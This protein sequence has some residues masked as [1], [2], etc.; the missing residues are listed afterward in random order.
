MN[1]AIVVDSDVSRWGLTTSV[2]AEQ[3]WT[4]VSGQDTSGAWSMFES[5]VPPGY[6]V[7]LHQHHSQDKCFWILAGDFVFEVG[8]KVYRL[9]E[10]MSLLAPR[11]I[12]HRWSKTS[13]GEGRMLILVQPSGK[14]EAFFEQIARLPVE[15][16]R[17]TKVM[18]RLFAESEMELLGPIMDQPMPA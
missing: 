3:V 6:G 17:D 15:Q 8:G 18:S 7:P 11:A 5:R 1:Q 13:D 2:S 9:S 10:G 4:K 12:A 16:Q 14:L